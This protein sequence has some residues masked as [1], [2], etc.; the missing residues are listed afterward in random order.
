MA[1]SSEK[2]PFTSDMV[3]SI[4]VLNSRLALGK[5]IQRFAE[6]RTVYHIANVDRRGFT[7]P[8]TIT[9]VK[10]TGPIKANLGQPYFHEG[11]L[12]VIDVI[13]L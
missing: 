12:L 10:Y 13:T 7:I 2:I 5:V 8:L 6:N 11:Q 9:G 1:L 3:G 4:L